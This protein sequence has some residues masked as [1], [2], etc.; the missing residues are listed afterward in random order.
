MIIYLVLCTSQTDPVTA[1]GKAMKKK[2]RRRRGKQR[3]V[4]EKSAVIETVDVSEGV[5]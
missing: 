5:C 3:Q 4:A 2:K 1:E